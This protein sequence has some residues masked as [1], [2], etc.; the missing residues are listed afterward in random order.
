[1]ERR[2][3]INAFYQERQYLDMISQ[4]E[5]RYEKYVYHLYSEILLVESIVLNS[6]FVE[7]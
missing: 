5:A 7:E 3:F 1:M 4:K 6:K 2:A